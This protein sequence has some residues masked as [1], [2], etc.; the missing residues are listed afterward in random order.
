MKALWLVAVG[1]LAALTI[2]LMDQESGLGTWL[3]LRGELEASRARI[4]KLESEIVELRGE[5]EAL[6]NDPFAE[7]RAIRERLGL[8]RPGEVVVRF[9]RGK[10]PSTRFP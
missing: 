3:R 4:A 1:V 10:T 8:A 6:E 7:E 9:A 2:A 5:A